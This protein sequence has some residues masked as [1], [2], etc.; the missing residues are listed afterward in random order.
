MQIKCI[1]DEKMKFSADMGGHSLLMDAKSPIGSDQGPT[2]KQLVLAGVAGCTAM[3]VIA[4]MKKHRQEVK[5]FVIDAQT[6]LTQGNPSVFTDIT[7]L[8]KATGNI[9]PEKLKEA[10]TLSQ[11]KYCGVSAMLAK[12]APIHYKIELNGEMIGEGQAKF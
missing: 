3:D 10:V 1:W 2:P 9:D 4:L 6:D 12:N 7:L 5:T 11:T 8:Y